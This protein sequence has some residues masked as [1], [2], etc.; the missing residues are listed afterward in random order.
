MASVDT[1]SNMLTKIRNANTAFKESVDVPYSWFGFEI[2]KIF[3]DEGYIKNFKRIED[4][5]QGIIRI[6]LK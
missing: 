6:Y 1:V 3:Q 2:L 4:K 5:K